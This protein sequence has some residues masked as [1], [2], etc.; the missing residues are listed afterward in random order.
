MFVSVIDQ[1]EPVYTIMPT[2]QAS[3]GATIM[4]KATFS[5][6]HYF[7][8]AAWNDE[9]N[10]AAFGPTA[11]R[12]SHGH[13]YTLVAGISGEVN[14][15][16]GMVA[17]L[18][19]IKR[20]MDSAVIQPLDFKQLNHQVPFFYDN[21]PCLE[22]L[23]VYVFRRLQQQLQPLGLVLAWVEVHESDELAVWYDGTPLPG[24][25]EARVFE[26]T[27]ED[28]DALTP[29]FERFHQH[30]HTSGMCGVGGT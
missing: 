25:N 13:N 16:T 11:N 26:A 8:N 10:R 24:V 12:F 15:T 29:A 18:K 17:N 19:D 6:S 23:S 3:S 20:V 28:S 14:S 30:I 22:A 2:P 27:L 21:Q 5:A 4:R 9:Q 7:W 1:Q